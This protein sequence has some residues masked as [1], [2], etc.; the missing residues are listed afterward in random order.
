M[1][2]NRSFGEE[3]QYMQSNLT[4]FSFPS[5]FSEKKDL[6]RIKPK[7]KSNGKGTE[8]KKRFSK[9]RGRTLILVT[10]PSTLKLLL[11]KSPGVHGST[12]LCEERK[13]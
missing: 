3:N 11:C 9:K 13:S 1:R 2:G 7:G 5:F 4:C 6:F 10:L 12:S 8:G